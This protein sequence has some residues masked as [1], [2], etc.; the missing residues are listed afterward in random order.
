MKK[1]FFS[2]LMITTLTAFATNPPTANCQRPTANRQSPTINRS[3]FYKAM[4]EN[5]KA[6]VNEQLEELKTAPEDIRP[7]FMGAM[8]MKKAG[9][10]GAP[11]TKL[12]LFKQGRKMLEEAIRQDPGNAEF[13]FLRL[14]VQEHAPGSLGYKNNLETDSEYIRKSYKSLPEE[15]QQFIAGYNKNSKFLKLGVS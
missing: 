12:H 2:C 15:V 1:I 4:E 3:A 5:D 8:F 14:M 9:L 13:R 7:A 11:A 10:G 6:L